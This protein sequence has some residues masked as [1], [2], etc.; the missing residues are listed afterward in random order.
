MGERYNHFSLTERHQIARLRDAKIPATEIALRLG[1]HV[2]A[3][4][5]DYRHR[6]E[7]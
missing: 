5:D 1:H 4:Q 6:Y 7:A 3:I 2:S